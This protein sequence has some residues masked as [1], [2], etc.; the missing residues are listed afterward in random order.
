MVYKSRL[1][2]K[3]FK[4]RFGIDY[5]ETFAPVVRMT[6]IRIL[7]AVSINRG[8]YVH[9][10]DVKNAFL[11][12]KLD[13][14]LYMEQSEGFQ[15]SIHPDF[16][17]KLNKTVYGWKQSPRAC[18]HTISPVLESVGVSKCKAENGIF[19]GVVKKASIFIAL[20]VDDLFIACSSLKVLGE[21]KSTL[22]SH[23]S[24]KDRGKIAHCLGVQIE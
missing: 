5:T 10:M 16:V 19:T 6:A 14:E 1:V 23:F 13:R 7:L 15:S 4:Q 22:A 8:L 11:N 2:A 18:Y 12:G 3:G 9:Q 17:C 21:I 20:Y 24:M